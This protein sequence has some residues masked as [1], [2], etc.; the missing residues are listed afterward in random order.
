M[1]KSME[2]EAKKT[3]LV[4]G[5]A[6]FIGSHLCERLA[7]EG[8]HVISLDNYFAGSKEN[9]VL[10]VEYREGHTKDIEQYIPEQVDI[11]YHLGEYARVAKSLEEPET[12]FALN[13]LGTLGVLEFWRKRKCKLVYAGSSTKQA[14]ERADGV[15]GRNLSP[16]T[17]AK[18]ANSDLVANY[19]RWYK[20]PYAITYFY[21]VYGPRERS[22]TERGTFI[23]TC[24]QN[25]LQGVPHKIASPGTQTRAFTHVSD[26]VAGIVLVGEKGEHEEYGISAKEVHSLLDV[27]NMFGGEIEMLPQTKSTR[28][29]GTTDTSKI[30]MLGWKQQYKLEDYV[31]SVKEK[32][33]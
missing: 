23:E 22:A 28:S 27:A 14:D 17:W 24:R 31:K 29:T 5:G 25:Y 30:E 12:V 32:Q 2:K 4:T 3:I 8:H 20:L 33:A 19:G 7:K 11:V 6:G 10:G 9:H 18:A 21:N 13:M 1:M 16:Y 15:L 26:T